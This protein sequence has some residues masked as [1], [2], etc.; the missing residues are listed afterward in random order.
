M[1]LFWSLLNW[2]VPNR[3]TDEF[4]QYGMAVV[5]CPVK[6]EHDVKLEKLRDEKPAA[7]TDITGTRKLQTSFY[8]ST[9]I[10]LH[11]LLLF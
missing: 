2:S 7:R 3:L 9:N 10:V 6:A 4:E 11:L 8:C 5:N 1:S